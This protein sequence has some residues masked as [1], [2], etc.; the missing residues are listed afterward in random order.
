MAGEAIELDA[1]GYPVDRNLIK[2][3]TPWWDRYIGSGDQV[4]S[5]EVLDAADRTMAEQDRRLAEITPRDEAE[6][7]AVLGIIVGRY[8]DLR[9]QF[10]EINRSMHALAE[11]ATGMMRL[12]SDLDR[13][14][15]GRHAKDSCLI[16]P[17][18]KSTG[19][20]LLEPGRVV[21]HT[22]HGRAIVVPAPGF[23]WLQRASWMGDWPE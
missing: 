18:G 6:A 14:E 19:N 4:F 12:I 22:V 2:P 5:H 23:D 21:G 20:L 9:D 11:S 17:G 7:H 3:G 16:C 10:A 8:P 1:D 13:C 15:H